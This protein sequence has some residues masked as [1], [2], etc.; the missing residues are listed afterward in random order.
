MTLNQVGEIAYDQIHRIVYLAA[1]MLPNGMFTFDFT[2][3]D[4]TPLGAVRLLRLASPKIV[5]AQRID[6]K[7]QDTEYLAKVR[8]AFYGDVSDDDFVWILNELHPDE[9]AQVTKEPS[10]ITA[11][12]FGRIPRHY[13]R[14][15]D[16]KAITIEM[17]DKMIAQVDIQMGNKT[18]IHT[19][20]TSHSPFLT[21]PET[22]A[23]VLIATTVR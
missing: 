15:T 3:E 2:F 12:R 21:M 20:Q 11:E 9:P 8:D 13:I 10:P 7:S 19:L 4:G 16:D 23:E 14:C 22:L 17:Q 5:G 6:P 18:H 1:F